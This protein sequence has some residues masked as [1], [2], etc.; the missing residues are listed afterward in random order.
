MKTSDAIVTCVLIVSMLIGFM[1]FMYLEYKTEC[2]DKI[3]A[4]AEEQRYQKTQDALSKTIGVNGER[5][6]I[7]GA[8]SKERD[9]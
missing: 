8:K 4:D 9:S 7:F 3:R 1:F 5:E 6:V 2:F